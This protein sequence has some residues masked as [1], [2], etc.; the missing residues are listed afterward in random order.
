[1][2]AIID[3]HEL[4]RHFVVRRKE[5]GR[6]FEIAAAA[7]GSKVEKIEASVYELDPATHGEFDFVFMGSLL[8]HLRD[9]IK[10]LECVRSVCRGSLLTI[11]AV[12]PWLTLLHPLRPIRPA[13]LAQQHLPC[14]AQLRQASIRPQQ[15]RPPRR[16]L[17]AVQVRRQRQRPP[18]HFEIL[19]FQHVLRVRHTHIVA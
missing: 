11:D 2:T 17:H 12:D 14:P 9:P 15:R 16:P 8:L 5:A 7:F 19:L 4:S 1:M 3:V 6:G 18:P 10:A 13:P